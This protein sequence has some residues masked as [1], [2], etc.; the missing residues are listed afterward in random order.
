MRWRTSGRRFL[1]AAAAAVA[2]HLLLALC[3]S[4]WPTTPRVASVARPRREAPL[5]VTLQER[6]G[7]SGRDAA[8]SAERAAPARV[9]RPSRTGTRSTPAVGLAEGPRGEQPVGVPARPSSR[10]ALTK[11]EIAGEGL[12]HEPG[13]RPVTTTLRDPLATLDPRAAE[14]RQGPVHVPTREEALVEEKTRVEGTLHGWADDLLAVNRAE[15]PHDVYWHD[16]QEALGKDFAVAFDISKRQNDQPTSSFREAAAAYQRAAES[17][18]STGSP[19]AADRRSLGP[20]RGFADGS[21]GGIKAAADEQALAAQALAGDMTWNKKLVVVIQIVQDPDGNI[22]SAQ[23][24]TTSGN[25]AYDGT[26][27]AQ[28]RKLA[29]KGV[30]GMPP[31]GRRRT[32]WAFETDFSTMPPLPIGGCTLDAF[33]MP[34]ECYYPLKRTVHTRIHLKAIY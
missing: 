19:V 1:A 25:K 21:L 7:V 6:S 17:Y 12:A 30:L 29:G 28:V 18:G 8:A 5:S 32:L 31:S 3:L 22:D 24:A 11:D 9:S 10:G 4:L 33:F 2:I 27:L 20:D 23:V 34:G 13:D 14:P 26:A 15:E 16:M